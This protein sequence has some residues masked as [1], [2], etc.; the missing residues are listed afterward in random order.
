MPDLPQAGPVTPSRVLV[1]ITRASSAVCSV[2]ALLACACASR[3]DEEGFVPTHDGY[4]LYYHKLGSGSE[5]VL[6]PIGVFTFDG[7][8][9]LARP[10]RTL[11]FYD[12]RNRGRSDA[13]SDLATITVE[14][15]VRDMETLR[16][17]FHFDSISVIGYSV[18]GMEVVLYAVE[19]PTRVK[20]VVQLGPVPLRFGTAY[21]PELDNTSD[22]SVFD[23]ALWKRIEALRAQHK[24]ETEP[25]EYCRI[26]LEF[27][28]V[29]LVTSREALTRLQPTVDRVCDYPNE[30]PVNF[31][32]QLAAH[33]E[34]SVMKL[35]V[36]WARVRDAVTMPVLTIHG[37]K[38]SQ[39]PKARLLTI[40][41]AA[42]QSWV[43]EPATV[44]GAIDSFL[45][46]QWPKGAVTPI[47]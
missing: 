35:D 47:D 24:D 46:G 38:D 30:W 14:N 10:H 40:D 6:V 43:D 5:A 2:L 32:K 29:G 13:V 23:E 19:H 3:A 16:D 25:Q 20:R 15:D 8:R 36:P 11:V 9:A 12:P 21:P 33:F 27:F 31:R 28:K 4:K 44:L 18:Y 45:D 34:G 17:H 42:H 39:L 7:L 26:T 1:P 41:N 22:R 37:R